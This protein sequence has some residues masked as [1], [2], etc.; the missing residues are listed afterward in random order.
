MPTTSQQ[1]NNTSYLPNTV[2]REMLV[3]IIW[4]GFENITIW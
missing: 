3:A 2:V 4:G 1:Y